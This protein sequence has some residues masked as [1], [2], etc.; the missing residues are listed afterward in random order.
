MKPLT[1]TVER[2]DDGVFVV[3]DDRDLVYG[4]DTSLQGALADYASSLIEYLLLIEQED[5]PSAKAEAAQLRAFLGSVQEKFE[6][7]LPM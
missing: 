5:A 1:L 2:G 4:D 6:V 7:E 3:S